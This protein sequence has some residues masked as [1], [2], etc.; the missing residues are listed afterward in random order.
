MTKTDTK[1]KPGQGG[2]PKGVRNKVTRAYKERI[3][4]VLGILDETLEADVKMMKAAEKVKLWMDLQEFIRPKLQ[5]MNLDVGA[6][7]KSIS[8]ITFEVVKSESGAAASKDE[9]KA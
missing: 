9:I 5:R 1:F 4:W 7:E 8:K 2:R 3:E 6:D